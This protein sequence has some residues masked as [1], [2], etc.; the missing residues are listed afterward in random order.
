MKRLLVTAAALGVLGACEPEYGEAAGGADVTGDAAPGAAP[1]HHL[2]VTGGADTSAVSGRVPGDTGATIHHPAADGNS[3]R[4]PDD[5]M[6]RPAAPAAAGGGE[7][8]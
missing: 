7:G 6:A 3:G 4:P 2:E 8:E 5:R 1:E